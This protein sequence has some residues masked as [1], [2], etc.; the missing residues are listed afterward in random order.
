MLC[1]GK[2]VRRPF[3]LKEVGAI[4]PKLNTI[5]KASAVANSLKKKGYL[6]K[7]DNEEW[8]INKNGISIIYRLARKNVED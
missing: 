8:Q 6:E 1:Y 3:T 5:K 4:F 2:M 7:G